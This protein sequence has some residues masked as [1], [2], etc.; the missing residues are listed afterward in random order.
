M[1]AQQEMNYEEF[2][3]FSHKFIDFRK[4]NF[5]EVDPVVLKSHDFDGK[6]VYLKNYRYPSLLPK[7]LGI[8]FFVHGYGEYVQRYAYLAQYFAE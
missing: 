4:Y 8:V 7:R 1:I 2:F 5:P 3:S 6:E